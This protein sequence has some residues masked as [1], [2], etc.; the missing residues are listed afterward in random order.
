MPPKKKTAQDVEAAV[1]DLQT[2]IGSIPEG[3][4]ELEAFLSAEILDTEGQTKER[5][6]LARYGKVAA[7]NVFVTWREVTKRIAKYVQD[8]PDMLL[9]DLLKVGDFIDK[10]LSKLVS[11]RGEATKMLDSKTNSVDKE[12]LEERVRRGALSKEKYI[13][14]SKDARQRSDLGLTPNRWKGE[15]DIH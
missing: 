5:A 8:H 14:Q 11:M 3:E 15:D 12:S 1:G 13:G 4:K 10:S 9:P 2:L 6:I 7:V